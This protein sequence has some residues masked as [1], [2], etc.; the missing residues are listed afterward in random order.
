M[1]TAAT[2]TPIALVGGE[3]LNVSV[4]VPLGA[5]EEAGALT[6]EK[7]PA[8]PAKEATM[9]LRLA[10]PVLRKVMIASDVC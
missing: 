8:L 9:L 6:I 3:N 4:V 5:T 1:L 2:F 7:S 10:F